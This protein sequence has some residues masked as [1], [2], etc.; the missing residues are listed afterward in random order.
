MTQIVTL[1][2]CNTLANTD[3]RQDFAVIHV[4]KTS[5]FEFI[6]VIFAPF[7]AI[8]ALLM[9]IFASL[10]ATN[11]LWIAIFASLIVTYALFIAFFTFPKAIYASLTGIVTLSIAINAPLISIFTSFIA[12]YAFM[13]GTFALLIAI[14][15]ILFPQK[16]RQFLAALLSYTVAIC[17]SSAPFTFCQ[18]MGGNSSLAIIYNV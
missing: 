15:V 2:A 4:E 8:H 3:G 12:T 11:A 7:I 14:T 9:A 1:C 18:R 13:I 10:T 16:R 6:M 17:F 5:F